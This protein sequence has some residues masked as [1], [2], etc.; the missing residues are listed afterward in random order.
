MPML[1]V[2][3]PQVAYAA[4]ITP[5][6]ESSW[7]GAIGDGTLSG[8]TI[9]V[10]EGIGLAPWKNN[11]QPTPAN[12]S[13]IA[14]WDFNVDQGSETVSPWTVNLNDLFT[15]HDDYWDWEIDSVHDAGMFEGVFPGAQFAV[16]QEGN[17]IYL[18]VDYTKVSPLAT[19]PTQSTVEFPGIGTMNKAV[20]L[21]KL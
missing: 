17:M 16:D 21:V 20:F 14:T 18:S 15:Q 7:T 13:G 8:D 2:L 6:D 9:P 11:F 5:G 12:I 4:T 10:V 19:S 3:G 1:Q